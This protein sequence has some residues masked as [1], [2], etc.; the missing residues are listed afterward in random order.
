MDH[1]RLA[2]LGMRRFPHELTEFE[3]NTF[4]TFSARERAPESQALAQPKLCLNFNQSRG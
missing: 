2:Y 3:L 1:W 4:F